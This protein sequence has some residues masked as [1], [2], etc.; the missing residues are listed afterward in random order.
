NG[1]A[2]RRAGAPTQSRYLHGDNRSY[3]LTALAGLAPPAHAGHAYRRIPHTARQGHA[4]ADAVRRYRGPQRAVRISYR[5]RQPEGGH[6]FR[7][8]HRTELFGDAQDLRVR[9]ALQWRPGRS[10]VAR[11]ERR[12]LRLSPG[13]AAAILAL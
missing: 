12:V 1:G 7:R 9:T 13:L 4:R 2:S 3:E 6:R 10:P 5:S 8:R 11:H